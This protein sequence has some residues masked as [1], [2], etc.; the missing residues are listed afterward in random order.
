MCCVPACRLRLFTLHVTGGELCAARQIELCA[1]AHLQA[2]CV[3]LPPAAAAGCGRCRQ[4]VTR[5][6]YPEASTNHRVDGMHCMCECCRCRQATLR[7]MQY[8]LHI[9]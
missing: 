3:Q 9:V 6:V 5:G 8:M 1:H 7:A 2:R 4:L